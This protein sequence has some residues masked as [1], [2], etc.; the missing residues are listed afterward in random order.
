MVDRKEHELSAFVFTST[1]EL[2]EH[3]FNAIFFDEPGQSTNFFTIF[4][5]QN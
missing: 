4:N 2:V 3:C 1:I 5:R